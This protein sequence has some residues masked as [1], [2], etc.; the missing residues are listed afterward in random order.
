M[1]I[2]IVVFFNSS[3]SQLEKSHQNT[4]PESHTNLELIKHLHQDSVS[5]V[6]QLIKLSSDDLEFYAAG[7]PD[8]LPW[9]GIIHGSQKVRDNFKV[10][11]DIMDYEIFDAR[12]FIAQGNQVVTIIS[13]KATARATGRTVESDI[14][15]IYTFRTGKI[16]KV[17]TYYDTAAYVDAI[18]VY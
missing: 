4:L 18:S 14:V 5:Y 3:C 13:A 7:P 12:E 6:D 15:R 16:I 17:R 1:L 9:A 10:I 2:L 11:L 8:Q